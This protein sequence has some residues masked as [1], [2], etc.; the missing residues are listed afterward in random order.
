M[1]IPAR[2]MFAPCLEQLGLLFVEYR[3]ELVEVEVASV[4]SPFFMSHNAEA[5]WRRLVASGAAPCSAFLPLYRTSSISPTHP[6]SAPNPTLSRTLQPPNTSPQYSLASG[7]TCF[8][9]PI[10]REF[11][12]MFGWTYKAMS[13][14]LWGHLPVWQLNPWQ[15]KEK[16]DENTTL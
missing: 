2:M 13:Y 15:H 6:A 3:F 7:N 5:H 16:D 12:E 10:R 8:I 14:H 1:T 9:L 4:H 11:A